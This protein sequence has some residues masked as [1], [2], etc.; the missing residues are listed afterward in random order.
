MKL[1]EK[2][3]LRERS[4][5]R[6]AKRSLNT[7]IDSLRAYRASGDAQY[8]ERANKEFDIALASDPEYL[9]ALYFR[10]VTWDLLGKQDFAIDGLTQVLQAQPKLAPDSQ[11]LSH[12]WLVAG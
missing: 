11:K 8:L 12:L 7:G 5:S 9:P 4:Q 10:S 6:E 1:R 2:S 3:E